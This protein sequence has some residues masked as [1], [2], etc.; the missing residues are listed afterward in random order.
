MARLCRSA[1]PGGDNVFS[2]DEGF[3]DGPLRQ[4]IHSAVGISPWL[5]L[6]C[7]SAV[8]ELLRFGDGQD[9][10]GPGSP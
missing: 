3:M 8:R 6:G 1:Q 2:I 7:K 10:A 9:A 5:A 4:Y